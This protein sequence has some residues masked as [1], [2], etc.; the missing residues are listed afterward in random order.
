MKFGRNIWEYLGLSRNIWEHLGTS[1]NIWEHLRHSQL[2]IEHLRS[3][4]PICRIDLY[5]YITI[6]LYTSQNTRPPRSLLPEHQ[7][8]LSNCQIVRYCMIVGL[9]NARSTFSV[10]FLPPH[11]LKLNGMRWH[12]VWSGTKITTAGWPSK[13]CIVSDIWLLSKWFVLRHKADIYLA[14][15]TDRRD[16]WSHN[17]LPHSRNSD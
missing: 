4:E 5:I 13:F 1:R 11:H 15:S 16:I 8:A 2:L 3:L 7:I 17:A 12:C 10:N 9:G 14:P 6:Y